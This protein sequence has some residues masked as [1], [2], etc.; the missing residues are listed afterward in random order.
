VVV[1]SH[2]RE[3][4]NAVCTDVLHLHSRT[5]VTY[6]GNF[7]TFEKTMRER[8]RNARAAA[9]AQDAKRKHMQAFIDRFRFNA[10]RAALVQSRI[11]ALERLAGEAPRS[12]LVFGVCRRWAQRALLPACLR[13]PADFSR[14]ASCARTCRVCLF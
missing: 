10:N 4:L 9:E 8:Q 5:I 7:D 14:A 12:L 13:S 6:R 2:A 3:F 11:K 1:V